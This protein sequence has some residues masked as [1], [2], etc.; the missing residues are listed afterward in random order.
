MKHPEVHHG[1]SMAVLRSCGK[2]SVSG[3][4]VDVALHR[5]AVLAKTGVAVGIATPKKAASVTHDVHLV[6]QD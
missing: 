5:R 4:D 6:L 2:P 1:S 3:M